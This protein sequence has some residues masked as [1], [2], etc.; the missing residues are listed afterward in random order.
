L[1]YLRIKFSKLKKD[2]ILTK[3]AIN[4]KKAL[5]LG[6]ACLLVLF[7]CAHNKQKLSP[8]GNLN[9]KSANVYYTQKDN[10]ASLRKAL[11]LYEKVLQ[12]NPQHVLALKRSADLIY[13]FATQIEPKKIEKGTHV[14]YQNMQHADEAVNYFKRTY[15]KYD[16]VLTVMA[17]FKDLNDKERATRRDASRKKESS[18]VKMVNIGRFQYENKNYTDAINTLE[19]VAALD[20][21]RIEPLRL[22]VAVYQETN[23]NEKTE[24]YLNKVLAINP[25]DVDL[26]KTMAAHYYNNEKYEEA[27]PYFQKI[28]T[29]QP[30]DINNILLLASCYTE[31]KDYS[32][33]L[34][35]VTKALKIDPQNIDALTAAKDLSKALNDTTAEIAYLKRLITANPTSKNLSEYCIRMISLNDFSD[36]MPYAEQWYTKDPENKD[37]VST[38]IYVAN[39]IGRKDLEQKYTQI[40]RTL[41]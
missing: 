35:I 19:Y 5:L 40:Y 13:Y 28:M 31:T 25:N 10:E 9:L 22:L 7:A 3:G 39:K 18:W 6:M 29:L 20:T 23:D 34:E 11:T 12:D 24:Y 38:C 16:S 1:T 17:N 27:I 32:K 41:P 15:A 33:A 14:E 30:T 21:T 2:T 37:A 4:M 8:Q 36:L 26:L